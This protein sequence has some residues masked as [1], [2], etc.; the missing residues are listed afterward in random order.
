[1]LFKKLIELTSACW[2]TRDTE[3]DSESD[4]DVEP[5]SPISLSD[6]AYDI[7]MANFDHAP[8]YSIEDALRRY[9]CTY[10]APSTP[11]TSPERQNTSQVPNNITLR[12]KGLKRKR[13]GSPS[14][15]HAKHDGCFPVN[16]AFAIS[17]YSSSEPLA[18]L[19]EYSTFPMHL[20]L[21][22]DFDSAFPPAGNKP[23]NQHTGMEEA[24]AMIGKTHDAEDRYVVNQIF[25]SYC[26]TDKDRSTLRTE[27]FVLDEDQDHQAVLQTGRAGI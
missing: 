1:M 26:H 3:A 7:Q 13:E 5:Q 10:E 24:L 6:S 18:L 17:R 8:P 27:D 2:S 19:P 21:Q 4:P 25:T 11:S 23:H 9:A 15:Q 20:D 12:G 22:H 16:H 14:V